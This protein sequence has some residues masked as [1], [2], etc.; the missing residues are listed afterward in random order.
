M[1]CAYVMIKGEM[2][3]S[4]T[5]FF[6]ILTNPH[7]REFY[8]AQYEALQAEAEFIAAHRAMRDS[9]GRA[10]SPQDYALWSAVAYSDTADRA[11]QTIPVWDPSAM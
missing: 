4:N 9:G 8:A 1:W 2:I 6:G 10:G 7:T 5:A 3:M 11:V